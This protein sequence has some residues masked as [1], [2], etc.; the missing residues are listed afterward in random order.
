[1]V[2]DRPKAEPLQPGVDRNDSAGLLLGSDYCC[3]PVIHTIPKTF[4][5]T[6]TTRQEVVVKLAKTTNTDSVEMF[7]K[8]H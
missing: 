8:L 3:A 4:R 5:F 1:M 7:S 6:Q 2:L